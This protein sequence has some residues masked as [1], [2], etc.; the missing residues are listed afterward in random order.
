MVRSDLN[1]GPDGL[2][3]AL[4]ESVRETLVASRIQQAQQA[5]KRGRASPQYQHGA[6]EK[7]HSLAF[8]K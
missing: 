6:L 1:I 2:T 7:L 8:S 4:W 5:D 3:N